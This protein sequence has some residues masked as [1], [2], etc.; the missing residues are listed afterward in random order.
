M[1][2]ATADRLSIEAADGGLRLFWEGRPLTGADHRRSVVAR[3]PTAPESQTLYILVSPLLGDGLESWCT[4][5]PVDSAALALELEPALA[6]LWTHP[7]CHLPHHPRFRRAPSVA[8]AREAAAT[9]TAALGIRRIRALTLS[10]A[11]RITGHDWQGLIRD[12][13]WRL[14]EYWRNRATEIRLMRRWMGNL[15]RNVPRTSLPSRDLAALLG[16]ATLLVGAG[17][18]LTAWLPHLKRFREQRSLVALD[19][20]LPALSAAG[21]EPDAIVALDA[22]L[23]NAR[24]LVPWNWDRSVLIADATV[25]PTYTRRF[26]GRTYLVATSAVNEGPQDDDELRALINGLPT[27]PA[28]G[29]VAATAIEVLTRHVGVTD[30]VL[31]GIDLTYRAAA[32]HGRMATAHRVLLRTMTRLA[33][34][35]GF[36]SVHD[37]PRREVM[38]DEGVTFES[39]AILADQARQ[40]RALIEGVRR[41]QPATQVTRL[42]TPWPVPS[43]GVTAVPEP[44][45]VDATVDGGTLR[46]TDIDRH[47]RV[48]DAA[49]RTLKRRL[50]LQERILVAQP[51]RVILDAGLSWVFAD[52]PQWPRARLT[53]EWAM[54]QR[55]RLLRAVRDMR[56]RVEAAVCATP[57]D[58]P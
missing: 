47:A 3:L 10:A 40:I 25:H 23:A 2:S 9:I 45:L 46:T 35:D 49:R 6:V 11:P 55:E 41:E 26:A 31:C 14:Q 42:S 13:E 36:E 56:R 50:D 48:R 38:S 18:S 19:T 44:P 22:Q 37:R 1:S 32:T 20:A 16:S 58:C 28:R 57:P 24:D 54:M 53:Q 15:V 17:P 51:D 7:A 43:L 27:L 39:D 21:I 12:L 34:G 5:L 8:A 52:L 30:L 33:H 4:T 29:S